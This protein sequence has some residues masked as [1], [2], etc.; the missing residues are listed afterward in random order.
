MPI[1]VKVRYFTTLRELAQRAVEEFELKDDAIL[2]DL[3]EA[4]ALK[5]G[6]EAQRYLYVDDDQKAIDPSLR[7]LI[8][9][10]DSKMLKGPETRLN[11]EDVVAIIPPI[12]GG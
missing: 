3:L 4:I 6:D 8:N 9:G 1:K 5:Y 10:M 12:G 7:I 11:D 2:R